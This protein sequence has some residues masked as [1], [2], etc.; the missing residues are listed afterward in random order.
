MIIF[1]FSMDLKMQMTREPLSTR[2]MSP[3]FSPYGKDQAFKKRFLLTLYFHLNYVR[4][5]LGYF[6]F[7]AIMVSTEKR[8]EIDNSMGNELKFINAT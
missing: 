3:N 5:R 1:I 8:L 6:K 4:L 7:Y 2:V